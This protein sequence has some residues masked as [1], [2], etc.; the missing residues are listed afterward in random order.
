MLMRTAVAVA[1][2][3][4]VCTG[5]VAAPKNAKKHKGTFSAFIDPAAPDDPRLPWQQN[6]EW[7]A[8]TF[9]I[10]RSV[11]GARLDA[12]KTAAQR[13]YEAL[14]EWDMAALM[15][16]DASVDTPMRAG[17]INARRKQFKRAL[18]GVTTGQGRDLAAALDET[19]DYMSDSPDSKVIILF[20]DASDV[21]NNV[22]LALRAIRQ[23]YVT[24]IIV[25][26]PG[27]DRDKLLTLAREAGGKLRMLDGEPNS[28]WRTTSLDNLTAAIVGLRE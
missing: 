27:A 13:I 25:G 15:M 22:I 5:G 10:D 1:L 28:A 19:R 21:E 16:F 12:A 23:A 17:H 9:L 14:D 6:R 20:T 26:L 2:V 3:A 4:V 24:L 11:D 7:L 8:V 18:A